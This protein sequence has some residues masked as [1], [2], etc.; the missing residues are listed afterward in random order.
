MTD[1]LQTTAIQPSIKM[2]ITL[3]LIQ[4]LSINES[5]T[6]LR[7]LKKQHYRGVLNGFLSSEHRWQEYISKE[8]DYVC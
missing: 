7:V 8:R 3:R 1:L 2:K 6:S 5:R 4:H